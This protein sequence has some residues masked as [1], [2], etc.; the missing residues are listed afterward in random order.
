MRLS[1]I[2]TV[3]NISMKKYKRNILFYIQNLSTQNEAYIWTSLH[4]Q[5]DF[6]KKF[7]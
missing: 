4:I 1:Y 5:G 7:E 2:A 6:I 3:L